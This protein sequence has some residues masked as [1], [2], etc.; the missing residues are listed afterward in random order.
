MEHTASVTSVRQLFT[1][2]FKFTQAKEDRLAKEGAIEVPPKQFSAIPF[3]VGKKTCQE[4]F[5]TEASGQVDCLYL[6]STVQSA[7]QIPSV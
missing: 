4:A 2:Y 6:L 5:G 1:V 7:E 3:S